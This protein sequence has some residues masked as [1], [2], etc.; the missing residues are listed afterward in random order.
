MMLRAE[1]TTEP[2]EG[3]GEP[4]AH[5][6][7]ARDCLR[8]AGLEPDF[9]PLGTSITGDRETLLPALAKVVETALDTGANRITLQVTVDGT[10][11]D[12]V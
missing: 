9:G 1:F 7:A 6:V 2:F 12:E 11:D 5:A 4:P 8:A 3:E 10:H